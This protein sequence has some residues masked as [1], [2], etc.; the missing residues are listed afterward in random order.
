MKVILQFVGRM[1][2]EVPDDCSD[3]KLIKAHA[4]EVWRNNAQFKTD[5]PGIGFTVKVEPDVIGVEF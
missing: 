1:A 5:K 4:L 3:L 2:V